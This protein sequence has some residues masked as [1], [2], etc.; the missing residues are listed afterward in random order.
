V[1]RKHH[2]KVFVGPIER[3]RRRPRA[4]ASLTR[5]LQPFPLAPPSAASRRRPLQQRA[6]RSG[7]R[8][9]SSLTARDETPH[10]RLTPA[11]P[12]PAL[13]SGFEEQQPVKL[14]FGARH[15]VSSGPAA[16]RV[17]GSGSRGRHSTGA[18]AGGRTVHAWHEGGSGAGGRGPALVTL[19]PAGAWS[20]S[21][22]RIAKRSDGFP[23][24]TWIG[25]SKG[26]GASYEQARQYNSGTTRAAAD[27]S[28]AGRAGERSPVVWWWQPP[29]GVAK[30]ASGERRRVSNLGGRASY[31]AAL[32]PIED[33][34][35]QVGT[36]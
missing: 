21:G 25:N 33:F 19:P 16:W 2:A 1:T 23:G 10:L 24:S 15:S 12:G 20:E 6:A 28:A 29:R 9:R 36:A 7:C 27:L 14:R 3:C 5:V 31:M 17:P 18:R 4:R 32:T 34:S 30:A 22:N 8:A 11:H 13:S 35:P 26:R